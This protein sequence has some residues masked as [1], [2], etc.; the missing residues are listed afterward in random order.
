M[1]I[2]RA[3]F[4]GLVSTVILV[5][6]A[7]AGGG[8]FQ[9]SLGRRFPSEYCPIDND[10]F[11]LSFTADTD[12]A[13]ITIQ[14]NNFSGATFL[15]QR[16]DNMVVV[17]KSVFDANRFVTPG[18]SACFQPPVGPVNYAGYNFSAAGTTENFFDQF[19]LNA[20]AWDLTN[21][22]WWDNSFNASAPRDSDDPLPGDRTGG[23]LAL[24]RE[25]DGA[26][27]V[28]TDF[29]ATGLTPGTLYVLTGWWSTATL[30]TLTITI[31]PSPC[32]DLDG[33]GVTDCAG[34]CNDS[35]AKIRTG[36][37]EVC[38]G[39]DNDC[40]GSIDDAAACVRTCTTPSKLGTDV[41][42]TTAVFDSSAPSV[43]WNG[44][45]YG[46]LWK[47]SRN[48]DQEIFFTHM[49]PA[50][51]KVGGDISVTGPCGDCV[52]PRLVWNGSEYGAVWGQND[53]ITFRR[54]D[55]A[56]TPIGAAVP[57]IDPAGSGAAEPDLVW[58]GS[59]YGVVWGQFVGPQ[60]IR[61]VRLD[62]EG[63]L[64]C[65]I[66]HITDDASFFGN[67]QPRVAFGG[68]DYGITWQGNASSHTQIFFRRVGQRQGLFPPLQITSH[69]SGVL[70]PQIVWA[71]NEWGIAWQ[72]HRT[73]TEIYFQRLTAFGVKVGAEL[74][75]TTA[76]G[77]SNEPTLAWTGSEYGVVWDDDRTGDLELW[78]A[79]ISAAG[80]KVGS[81][82]Q[83]T[84]AT[85]QSDHPSLAWGG[86]KFAVAWHDDRFAGESEVLFLRLGCNCV[87]A[88]LD[89]ASSCVE[90][91][92]T[93]ATVFGGAPQICDGLNNDCNSTTWPLLAG[94][95][96][97]DA[98]GDGVFTC[99]GGGDCNDA[100][101]SIWATPG[102]VRSLVLSHNKVTAT[103]T[104]G[105]A[106]P[107]LPGATTFVYDTLRST[108]PTNFT[109]STTCVETNDGANTSA[110]D[111][112]TP[113]A[114]G[115]FF[116][117]VRAENACPSG[118][119][120]LGRNTA[121]TPTPGRTCP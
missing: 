79:R 51:T 50:G 1:R 97:M 57:L 72:D 114:G 45:D 103:S 83:L 120:V 90:C 17:P 39:R 117:L 26:V 34:D 81:D 11:D 112:T 74:R 111:A 110:I 60:Q 30:N 27:T 70:S 49:T 94:T 119:G 115:K 65:P 63:N 31:D 5:G 106:A 16:F 95:N 68:T 64:L 25:T 105:W 41:R 44:I 29:M 13:K 12:R 18:F 55:R 52:N 99:G 42:V 37:A 77:V 3:G 22:G 53:E 84:T 108:T 40:N 10:S 76:S 88:D 6:V 121:G 19:D 43:A 28:S 92:D 87:D 47:D 75:V 32:K 96:E 89:G 14:G 91:D 24:G 62:R 69:S 33:D 38:D 113:G 80:A 7:H 82:L 56:G 93:H 85:G 8:V 101:P 20:A 46:M 23:A 67:A 21:Y 15:A 4:V 118:L 59:E 102:E 100:N 35:D 109:S 54:F 36:A 78:Y 61:F 9:I 48:G 71:G 2:L 104:L 98:D 73:F 107:L 58:T 66:L 116:Y 86:S